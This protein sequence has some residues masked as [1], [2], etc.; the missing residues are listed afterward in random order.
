MSANPTQTIDVSFS[1][2]LSGRKA[3]SE[4]HTVN[5]IPDY[6]YG[7]DYS[8]RQKINALPGAYAFFRALTNQ[9]VPLQRQRIN[10]YGLKVG[11]TQFADV[12]EQVVECA[13][14]LGIGIPSTFIINDPT[15]NAGAYAME[16]GSPLIEI[17]SGMLERLTPGELKTVIGHECGHVHNNH[18]L[19]NVAVKMILRA[20]WVDIPVVGQIFSLVSLPLQIALM[21]WSRA[22]EVTADRAGIICCDD[23]NDALLVEAKFM[24]GATFNRSDVNIEAVLKQY[25]TMRSTPA[26]FLEIDS[27]HPSSVRRI[28]AM[29]EF[30]NSE[31]LYKWRPDFKNP[32][33][34]LIGK[35]ELDARCEKYV[36]VAKSGK[37]SDK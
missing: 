3:L 25:D 35:Q 30:I 27:S 31:I 12:H 33:M 8:I 36:S 26:R 34:T 28:F 19:Y 4:A 14:I 21:T 11:P 5:G 18:S 9:V 24:Y 22:A 13:R 17:N 37:R 32:S 23:P 20:L 16:D 2:Y 7:S 15:I 6:A 1:G 10:Q 29:K